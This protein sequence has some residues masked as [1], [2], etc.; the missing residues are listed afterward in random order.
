VAGVATL[1]TGQDGTGVQR[2]TIILH[3][4][5]YDRVTNALSLSIVGLTMEMEVHVLLTYEALRRFVKGHFEDSGSGDRDMYDRIHHG[6]ESGKFHTIE[7]KLTAAKEMGL[8]LYACSTAMATLGIERD[9]LVVDVDEVMGLA[10]F[11]ELAKTAAVNWY[12]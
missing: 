1:V 4:G 8:K 3:D 5:S 6:I 7:Y 12:I 11:L 10:A 2:M 9:D